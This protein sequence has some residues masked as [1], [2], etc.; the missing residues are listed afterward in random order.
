MNR[1]LISLA[2]LVLMAAAGTSANAETKFIANS[3]YDG[4]H[5]LS[6]F[7]YV[8]WADIV[9]DLSGGD[10][11]P[12]VYTG[13]VLLAPRA[14]L[15]GAQDNVVQ[16]ANISAVYIPSEMPVANAVQELG[17]NYSD[18][19][20]MIFAATDFSMHNPTQL[21]EWT[22]NKI[23]YL[24]AYTTPPYILFCTSPVTTLAEFKGKRIRTAG[25]AVSMWVE[26][27]GGVPVNVPSSEM[28]TGLE[29]G[30]LDCATNAANDLIDRSLWEVAK[31]TTL[32][33]TGMY[34]AGPE[35]GYNTDFWTGLSVEQRSVLMEATARSMARMIINYAQRAEDALTEAQEKGN[36]V[37]EPGED[38]LASVTAFR[39]TSLAAAI[40]AAD[41]ATGGEGQALI[42]DF[43]ATVAKWD[44]LL[45]EVD[46]NDEDALTALAMKEIYGT[47]DPATYGVN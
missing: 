9:K 3:F 13:T 29:R 30:S 40:A 28:Y 8:E 16:V 14:A 23:V 1:N 32:L 24:G 35:W 20:A 31:H 37:A 18:P 7:G 41:A 46:T 39:E 19:K 12:E 5:P 22:D 11:A 47:L 34:W 38:L 17:F 21:K 33:P 45:A 44:A 4:G 6:K 2:G 36:T 43:Q 26:E 10:L 42:D 25:S 15:Q 27:A